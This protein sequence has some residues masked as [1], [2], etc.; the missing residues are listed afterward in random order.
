[1]ATMKD[2][3]RRLEKTYVGKEVVYEGR[4]YMVTGIDANCM[5]LIDK[6]S[7]YND[8]TAVD[9]HMITFNAEDNT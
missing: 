7:E 9:L 3:I 5:V 4:V 6:T 1:M 2:Y 8:D